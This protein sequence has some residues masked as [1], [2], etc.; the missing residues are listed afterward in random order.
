MFLVTLFAL[1]VSAGSLAVPLHVR[2]RG[3]ASGSVPEASECVHHR[4]L[5][6]NP[7]V[8][9]RQ[10][11]DARLYATGGKDDTL[12][13]VE[14][15][16]AT[17]VAVDPVEAAKEQRLRSSYGILAVLLFT[18]ASNQWSRQALYYLCDFS[19]NADPYRH[20]NAALNFDKETYAA[21][22]SFG[23]TAVFAAVSLVAGG[24]SDKYYRNR[25]TAVACTVWC[26]EL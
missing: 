14:V 20:I 25:V 16:A 26:V 19:A 5:P 22:A 6:Q 15:V 12:L 1:C 10:A 24:V 7:L 2:S 3:R 21:L 23:F 9:M 8:T 17:A 13:E 4:R 11:S 18:F